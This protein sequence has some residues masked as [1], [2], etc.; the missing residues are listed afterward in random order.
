MDSI[1]AE[2]GHFERMVYARIRPN[3]DLVESIERLCATQGIERAF[4]RGSLGSLTAACIETPAGGSVVITGPAV[5]V[6]NISG[7]VR[8]DATGKPKAELNGV[9]S[10]ANGHVRGGRFVSGSNIVCITFEIAL[11]EWK[12]DAPKTS[13]PKPSRLSQTRLKQSR[14]KPS[15]LKPSRLK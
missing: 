12:P 13:R 15:R 9:V 3:E 4:V 14:L 7:E 5:E 11:E 10:D 1:N 6:V 8:T 2:F